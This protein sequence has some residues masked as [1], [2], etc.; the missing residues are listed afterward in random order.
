VS[1]EGLSFILALTLG[2]LIFLFIDTLSEGLEAAAGAVERLRA[3][4][5]V[6]VSALVTALILL[7]VGRRGGAPPRG[8]ALAVFIALGVGAGAIAQVIIEVGTLIPRQSGTAGLVTLP[9]LSGIVAG[10]A[11]MYATALLV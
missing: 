11:I 1:T 8:I 10:L 9:S 5:L 3:E 2:L 6:W 7:A 4:T